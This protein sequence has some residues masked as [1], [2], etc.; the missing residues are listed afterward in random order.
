MPH[1]IQQRPYNPD[2]DYQFVLAAAKEHG[3]ASLLG[4]KNDLPLFGILWPRTSN[5]FDPLY[6]AVKRAWDECGYT[7][8]KSVKI[9]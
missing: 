1:I 5:E 4:I 2:T 9:V 7:Y 3:R 8:R 6:I